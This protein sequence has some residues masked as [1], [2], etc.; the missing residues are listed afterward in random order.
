MADSFP[1]AWSLLLGKLSHEVSSASVLGKLNF[2][3]NSRRAGAFRA[4]AAFRCESKSLLPDLGSARV[5]VCLPGLSSEAEDSSFV[6]CFLRRLFQSP[7][8]AG[9]REGLGVLV[10]LERG[11][12]SAATARFSP[13]GQFRATV[14]CLPSPV[15]GRRGAGR[16]GRPAIVSE[17]GLMKPRGEDL[18]FRR[19]NRNALGS[20]SW[21]VST[22]FVI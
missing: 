5:G 22:H 21:R 13:T 7:E 6:V 19:A 9:C 20:G 17:G 15:G 8:P 10:S 1:W 18:K 14:Q 4:G 3:G 11:G 2:Q 12:R 16:V